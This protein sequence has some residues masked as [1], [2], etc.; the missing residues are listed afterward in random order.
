[1]KYAQIVFYCKN[2]DCTIPVSEFWI[3]EDGGFHIVTRCPRC[4][5]GDTLTSDAMMKEVY[6]KAS[7]KEATPTAPE[8]RWT[9]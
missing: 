5:L 7:K 2:C 4:K 6:G 8:P 1:M 3:A 9:M